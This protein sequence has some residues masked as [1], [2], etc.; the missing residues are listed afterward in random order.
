[1]D[2]F[3]RWRLE[4][5]PEFAS[6]CGTHGRFDGKLDSWDLKAFE[7]RKTAAK[8]FLDQVD[9]LLSSDTKNTNENSRLSPHEAFNLKLLRYDLE[10]F[11][12]GLDAKGY[13]FPLS[14]MEGPQ[15]EFDLVFGSW[16]DKS[17]EDGFSNLLSRLKAF[18][19]QIDEKI[20]CLRRGV[21]SG[22]VLHACSL[23]D[24]PE[25][26]LALAN[27]GKPIVDSAISGVDKSDKDAEA[28]T[29][30]AASVAEIVKVEIQPAFKRL[31]EFLVKVYLPATRDKVAARPLPDGPIC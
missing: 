4:E 15:V 25:A 24:V 18:P 19:R 21:E 31:H 2:S 16:I 3:W 8:K 7:T 26:I 14:L 13:L 5:S 12:E 17:A 6:M 1:M 30:L 10:T 22:I 27:D 29:K 11:V 20:E 23:V 9:E 28:K